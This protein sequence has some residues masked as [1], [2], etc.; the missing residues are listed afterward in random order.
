MNI[1]K[2]LKTKY[3]TASPPNIL[4]VIFLSNL[5]HKSSLFILKELFLF[6]Y[7]IMFES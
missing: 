4:K 3:Y 2:K 7:R 5:S 1:S 6:V